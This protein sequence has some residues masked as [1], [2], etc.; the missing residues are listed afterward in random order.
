MA[1]ADKGEGGGGV[2]VAAA[3]GRLSGR[4][5]GV[6]LVE[7]LRLVGSGFGAGADNAVLGLQDDVHALRQVG[8]NHRGQADAQVDH[9]A[10]LQL[11]GDT[12]GNK[13][14]DLRLFHYSFPPSTM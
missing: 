14:L 5:A 13:A 3:L 9:V 1:A 7:G 4:S 12:L 2:N 6:R 11:G 8:G 10:V